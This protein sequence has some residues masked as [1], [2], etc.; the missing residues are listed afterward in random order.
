MARDNAVAAL[1]KIIKHQ[2][3]QSEELTKS[4]INHWL[5]YLPITY[6]TNECP[7]QHDLLC[8]IIIHKSELILGS[9][10]ENLP[11]VLRILARIYTTKYSTKEINEK[12]DM[13]FKSIKNNKIL[14][15]ISVGIMHSSEGGK[16]KTKLQKLLL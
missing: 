5:K 8:D 9:N 16:I 3:T 4:L 14:F 2:G 11:S 15:E 10:N 13:I 1:G 12:I 7:E 6:D